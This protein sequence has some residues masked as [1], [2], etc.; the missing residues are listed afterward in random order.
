MPYGELPAFMARLRER[1]SCQRRALEF[2]HPD[3]LLARRETIGATWSE[4]DL[5]A[6]VVDASPASA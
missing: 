1:D 4:I 6:G 3:A 2:T 5:D